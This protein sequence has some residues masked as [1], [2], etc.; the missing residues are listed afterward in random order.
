[1]NRALLPLLASFVLIA[2]GCSSGDKGDKAP[3]IRP[4]MTM[5]VGASD[6]TGGAVYSGEVRARH[7]GDLGFRVP[8]K[9][10]ARVVDVGASVKKGQVLA[11]LDPTDNQMNADA[12]RAAVNAAKTDLQFASAEL[13]RYKTLFEKNFVSKTAL[14]QKSATFDAAK[15][16]LEQTEAQAGV[17]RNQ[18]GYTTLVA[19]QDGVITAVLA[20]SG[21]VVAAGQAVMRLAR[22]DEK[23]VLISI[24]ETRL[25]AT[26]AA[27][28]VAVR[29][30]ANPEKIYRGQVRELAPS[31]D[32]GTRTFAT[33][34]SILGADADVAL[35]MTA[36]VLFPISQAA[37][38]KTAAAS[39][40]IPLTALSRQGDQT[41]VWVIDGKSGQVAMRQVTV[42]QYRE[43]GIVIGSG[44]TAGDVIAIA[45]VH[46]LV[47]GQT[48][49]AVSA[50]AA[51]GA[52][53]AAAAKSAAPAVEVV[54]K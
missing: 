24:P 19:D 20:E 54:A 38:G 18:V 31:A 41:A 50:Q 15:A 17:T 27:R 26:R 44:L 42:K 33:R 39:I 22:P 11:R 49:R 52:A 14:D 28:E 30:W 25:A 47:A 13:D 9:I 35:G 1:V 29:L 37:A 40:V 23:E 53:P 6:A 16:R 4:V 36:N 8:G 5:T 3:I 7:E 51:G 43:D 46:K 48:V 2:S 34:I 32:A 21:Q 45:G 12:S 10:T